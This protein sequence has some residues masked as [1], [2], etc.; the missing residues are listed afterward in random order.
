MKCPN[1]TERITGVADW[2]KV[3]LLTEDRGW[4]LELA[5]IPLGPSE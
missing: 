2:L 4:A 5:I 3:T 1:V